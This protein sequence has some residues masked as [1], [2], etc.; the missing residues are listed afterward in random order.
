LKGRCLTFAQR[1]E[2]TVLRAQG[3]S[4]KVIGAVVGRSAA[5]GDQPAGPLDLLH[6][7]CGWIIMTMMRT[8]VV[9]LITGQW[10]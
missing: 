9:Q 3:R 6:L 4:L 8:N 7:G 2:I 1:G 5:L 10:G